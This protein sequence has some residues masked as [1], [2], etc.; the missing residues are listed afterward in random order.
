MRVICNTLVVVL[1]LA[2]TAMSQPV[3][4]GSITGYIFDRTTERG[5]RDVNVDILQSELGAASLPSG[6]YR[7]EG[8]EPGQYILEFSAIGYK[9]YTTDSVTVEPGQVTSLIVELDPVVLEMDQVVVT[10]TRQSRLLE[11][12]PDITIIQSGLTKWKISIRFGARKYRC[13]II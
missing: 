11:Q 8:V 7:I 2:L 13:S 10:A 5:V 12:T 4:K 1:F 6:Q 3:E 9:N